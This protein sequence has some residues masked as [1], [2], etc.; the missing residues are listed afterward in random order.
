MKNKLSLLLLSSLLLIVISCKKEENVIYYEGG[1]APV[2]TAS[3]TTPLVLD[4]SK[5]N[6]AAIR[7]DWTNPDYKFTTGISSLDVSYTLQVDTAGANFTNPLR[8]EVSIAKDLGKTFTVKELN[9]LFG[10]AKLNLQEN[11]PHD[12]E[13]RVK[14]STTSGAVPLY[15]NVIKIR[16]TPYLDVAV[17]VPTTGE[18]WATGDA[19][20]S[21]WANPLGNPYDVSQKF[22]RVSNT[23]YQ[24]TVAMPGG[25]NYKILQDNGKWDTQYHM[26]SGGT[27]SGGSFEKKDA[28]PG[29]P[30]PPTAGTYKITVN[31]ITGKYTVEKQ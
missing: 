15:S 22:T 18:L 25:G 20:S 9:S 26:L 30:G 23:L 14:A 10:A 2:L 24:L 12:I 1:T 3:T 11:K 16:I 8:Q 5:A 4:I 28:D 17:P 29:F 27:W 31:F 21:G 7:F 13:F 6:T 19:F